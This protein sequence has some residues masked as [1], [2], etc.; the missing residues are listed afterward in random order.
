MPAAVGPPAPDA[1]FRDERGR[2]VR[3]SDFWKDGPVVL[4]FLRHFGCPFCRLQLEQMQRYYQAIRGRGAEVVGICQ[5]TAEETAEFRRAAGVTFPCVGDPA[6]RSYEAYGLGR[7]NVWQIF[8]E[9]ILPGIQTLW[10]GYRFDVRGTLRPHSDWYQLPG[11]AIVDTDGVVR[12]LHR[13]HHP[14]DIPS[15]ADLLAALIVITTDA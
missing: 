5:G 8:V 3:L 1:V 7:G 6:K 10:A 13:G 15:P 4:L 11:V 2:D 9:P 14:G 12:Y